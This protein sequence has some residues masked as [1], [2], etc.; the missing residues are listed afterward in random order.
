L[1]FVADAMGARVADYR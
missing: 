1:N